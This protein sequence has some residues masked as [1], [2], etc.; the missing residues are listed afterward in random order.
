LPTWLRA[1]VNKERRNK[2]RKV[3]RKKEYLKGDKRMK[4]EGVDGPCVSLKPQVQKTEA[5][6]RSS[7]SVYPTKE[8]AAG[9]PRILATMSQIIN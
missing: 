9:E 1:C 5:G 3:Q 8:V 7:R 4:Q 2:R 6:R